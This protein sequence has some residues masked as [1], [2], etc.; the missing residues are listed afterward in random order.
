MAYELPI[1]N[2]TPIPATEPAAVPSLWNERYDEIDSNFARIAA[3]D[4]AGECLTD[5]ATGIK[6]VQCP[7]FVL[8]DHAVVTVKFAVT[9]EAEEL[10]LDVNSTGAKPILLRGQP[11]PADTFKKDYVYTFMYDGTAWNLAGGSGA[12]G[13]EFLRVTGGTITGELVI[14]GGLI[15]KTPEGASSDDAII[16]KKD[17]DKR[18]TEMN[19]SFNL[20]A[21]QATADGVYKAFSTF[22]TEQGIQ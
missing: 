20:G 11:A 18:L 5:A 13:D 16:T 12:S 2:I 6:E 3:F 17:L 21:T 15:V 19:S 22:A 8:S 4:A 7:Y 9:N 1:K 14:N 10:F